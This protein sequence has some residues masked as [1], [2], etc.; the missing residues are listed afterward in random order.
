[1]ASLID[2]LGLGA[3]AMVGA[4]TAADE[5]VTQER[6]AEQQGLLDK[7][8]AEQEAQDREQKR[9]LTEAQIGNYESLAQDRT[10]PPAS[11]APTAGRRYDPTRG[12]IVDVN[13]GEA[14]VPEGLPERPQTERA[15][16]RQVV[17]GSVVDID[18]GTA[19]PIQGL[20]SAGSERVTA[21]TRAQLADNAV[22]LDLVRQARDAVRRRP[23]S[24]GAKFGSG[25]LPMMGQA[26]EMINQRIDPDGV[27]VR[28]LI[29]QISARKI[30]DMSG[31]AVTISEFPR[32]A[33]FV[34]LVW[35]TPEKIEANLAQLERE[36]QVVMQALE[37]G[38]TL[39]ELMQGGGAPSGANVPRGTP[40][41]PP[42]D[43]E[44]WRAGRRNP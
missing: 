36:I 44:A 43:F 1:M 25:T 33:A 8:K 24:V 40:A 34:P 10:R 28:A 5:R 32:L 38:V 21:S 4:R 30:K 12:V 39:A 2:L 19:T 35:D 16:R 41:T 22:Q 3:G 14:I 20:P 31:A 11:S 15:P 26:G 6:A 29:A 18:S 23:E 9:R 13:S 17:G 37:Q 7:L 42:P 27:P